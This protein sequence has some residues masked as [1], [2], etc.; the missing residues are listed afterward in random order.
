[1][2]LCH[3]HGEFVLWLHCFIFMVTLCYG[4]NI[5][6]ICVM[7]IW[8]LGDIVSRCY[9]VAVMLCNGGFGLD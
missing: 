9:F 5:T 1:M 4:Y 2:K 8:C 7:D 6:V 3:D